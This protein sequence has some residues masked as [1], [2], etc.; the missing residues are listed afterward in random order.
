VEVDDGGG[1]GGLGFFWRER[2][3]N[4][5]RTE[6]AVWAKSALPGSANAAAEA[7]S[8]YVSRCVEVTELTL[9]FSKTLTKLVILHV[10]HV[11]TDA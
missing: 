11:F 8:E 4:N 2:G 7:V 10:Q 1:G 3:I 5:G 6:V 9:P